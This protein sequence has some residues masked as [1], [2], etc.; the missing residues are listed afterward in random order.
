M[1]LTA[2]TRSSDTVF[3]DV[4]T[5][6]DIEMQ[7]TRRNPHGSRTTDPIILSRRYIILSYMVE[8]D[9]VHYPLA[10][11]Q[12]QRPPSERLQLTI[13]RLSEELKDLQGHRTVDSSAKEISLLKHEN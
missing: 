1:L 12:N 2:F 10:L 5:H 11:N 8:F 6:H 4:L 3:V 13:R 7:N 9:K